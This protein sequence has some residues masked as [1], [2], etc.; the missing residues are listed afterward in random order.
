MVSFLEYL[1]L[2]GTV[3]CTQQL[4]M[5]CGMDCDMFFGILIFDAEWWFCKGYS[6]CMMADFQNGLISRIFSVLWKGLL[7]PTTQNDF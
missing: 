5:I 6:D 1:V 4:E 3:F 7:Q 2:F